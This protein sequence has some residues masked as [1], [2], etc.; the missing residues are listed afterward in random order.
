MLGKSYI[1]QRSTSDKHNLSSYRSR[2]PTGNVQKITSSK[3]HNGNEIRFQ[4]EIPTPTQNPD[5]HIDSAAQWNFKDCGLHVK[6]YCNCTHKWYGDTAGTRG[7][8]ERC[9]PL[10]RAL[11]HITAGEASSLQTILRKNMSKWTNEWWNTQTPRPYKGYH[12]STGS[13]PTTGSH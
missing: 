8:Q 7:G 11:T 6:A 1:Y 4:Q 13:I 12:S 10:F 2:R 3:L 9:D 5:V